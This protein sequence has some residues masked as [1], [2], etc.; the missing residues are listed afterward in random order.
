MEVTL[1][2]SRIKKSRLRLREFCRQGQADVVSKSRNKI[3]QTWEHYFGDHVS[4]STRLQTDR[5]P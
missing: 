4:V 1:T 2:I 3:H 5:L